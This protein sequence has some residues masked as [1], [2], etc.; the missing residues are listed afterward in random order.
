METFYLRQ[1]FVDD[2]DGYVRRILRI[3]AD[4]MRA[5]VPEALD[6]GLYSYA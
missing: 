2:D 5:W 3:R 1:H 6:G 4:Q